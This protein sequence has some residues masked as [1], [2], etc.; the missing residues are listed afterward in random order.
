MK[1]LWVTFL[2]CEICGRALQTAQAVLIPFMVDRERVAPVTAQAVRSMMLMSAPA[3]FQVRC[4][5]AL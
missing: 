2:A 3:A 5:D 1:P 4:T